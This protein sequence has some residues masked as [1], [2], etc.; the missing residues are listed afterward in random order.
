VRFYEDDSRCLTVWALI[1][2]ADLV[3]F[4]V[5]LDG[6]PVSIATFASRRYASQ[7]WMIRI[8]EVTLQFGCT[9]LWLEDTVQRDPCSGDFSFCI[10]SIVCS[11]IRITICSMW[12]KWSHSGYICEILSADRYKVGI[13]LTTS[14][15]YLIGSNFK[16]CFQ[17]VG[18]SR[19]RSL[20]LITVLGRYIWYFRYFDESANSIVFPLSIIY[21]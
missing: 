13:H 4:Q 6:L 14:T 18:A 12:L 11:L 7:V 20:N 17:F 15:D 5:S 21:Q 8:G 10:G 19:L 16:R 1:S 3:L 9:L 2:E